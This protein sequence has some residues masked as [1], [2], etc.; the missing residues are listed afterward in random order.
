MRRWKVKGHENMNKTW[1]IWSCKRLAKCDFWWEKVMWMKWI[2]WMIWWCWT[3]KQHL[4]ARPFDYLEILEDAWTVMTALHIQFAPLGAQ[5]SANFSEIQWT[6]KD[7]RKR[8]AD[9][10]VKGCY[11]RALRPSNFTCQAPIDLSHFLQHGFDPEWSMTWYDTTWH[12]MTWHGC[13]QYNQERERERCWQHY[14]GKRFCIKHV[15]MFQRVGE[16]LRSRKSPQ[17][18]NQR[19]TRDAESTV[20]RT[21][22]STILPQDINI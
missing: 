3:M 20:L 10:R 18:R 22:M 15:N 13:A 19:P 5:N 9:V 8:V 6:S 2:R 17:R 12:D 11:P 7:T 1:M 4:P 21:H 16:G 14:I